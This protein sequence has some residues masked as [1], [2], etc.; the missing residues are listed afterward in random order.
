M[1]GVKKVGDCFIQKYFMTEKYEKTY[2]PHVVS[3]SLSREKESFISYRF[4]Y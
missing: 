3:Y 2:L 4:K 1:C